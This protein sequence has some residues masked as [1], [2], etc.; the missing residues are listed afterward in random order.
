MIQSGRKSLG[1]LNVEQGVCE[2]EV[3]Y[4]VVSAEQGF[5][6]IDEEDEIFVETEDR[7]LDDVHEVTLRASVE[8]LVD[9]AKN[10]FTKVSVE[11][12][13]FLTL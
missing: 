8:V 5:V 2:Y 4:E 10:E 12:S 1:I 11:R 6:M 7:T 3:L 13:F 9:Y